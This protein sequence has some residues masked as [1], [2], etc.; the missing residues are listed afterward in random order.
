MP[1]MAPVVLNREVTVS[2]Q[3]R[4]EQRNFSRQCLQFVAQFVADVQA[5]TQD[6]SGCNDGGNPFDGSQCVG[7]KEDAIENDGNP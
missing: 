4:I 5:K 7:A 3:C 6:R 2:T 1:V